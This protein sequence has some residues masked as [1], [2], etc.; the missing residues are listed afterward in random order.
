MVF[1]KKRNTAIE[2]EAN[3]RNIGQ[4]NKTDKQNTGKLTMVH[5]RR[6]HRFW[7]N[8]RIKKQIGTEYNHWIGKKS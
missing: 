6:N 1:S 5:H 4:A 8:Q 3:S 7:L 2:G